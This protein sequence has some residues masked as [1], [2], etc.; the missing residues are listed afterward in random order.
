M[1]IKVTSLQTPE[2]LKQLVGDFWRAVRRLAKVEQNYIRKPNAEKVE[3]QAELLNLY[4]HDMALTKQKTLKVVNHS[5]A[6]A[7][8]LSKEILSTNDEKKRQRLLLSL[9]RLVQII[10]GLKEDAGIG[11]EMSRGVGNQADYVGN[12]IDGIR[13]D[14]EAKISQ[15]K[16]K[17]TIRKNIT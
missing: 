17:G 11:I 14:T 6:V 13:K 1:K 8:A 3:P 5:P 9:R 4:H 7:T 10:I 2:T 16:N 12:Q 15:I